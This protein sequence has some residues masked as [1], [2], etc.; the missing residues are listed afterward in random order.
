VIVLDRFW[1]MYLD[2][3][4]SISD[5]YT[6]RTQDYKIR[7]TELKLSYGNGNEENSEKKE[8]RERKRKREREMSSSRF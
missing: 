2:R 5:S 6:V 7:E 8:T 4:L 3:L 1:R